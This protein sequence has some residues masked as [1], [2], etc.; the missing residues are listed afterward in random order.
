M[1]SHSNFIDYLVSDFISAIIFISRHVYFNLKFSW[2]NHKSVAEWS[3]TYGT[4]HWKTIWNSYTKLARVGFDPTITEFHSDALT[5]WA[6]RQWL[7]LG[8]RA[9]FVQPLQFHWFFFIFHCNFNMSLTTKYIHTYPP[10]YL[11]TYVQ[12][13]IHMPI[14]LYLYT[15]KHIYI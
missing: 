11:H 1:Y 8:L 13:Y 14:C 2:G 6:N 4:Q 10:T 15:F 7:Q 12:T 3:D 5:D 9:N